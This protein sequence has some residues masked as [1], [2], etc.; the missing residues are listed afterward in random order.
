MY[1]DLCASEQKWQALGKLSIGIAKTCVRVGLFASACSDIRVRNEK[2]VCQV[3]IY[4]LI[5][6]EFPKRC[7]FCAYFNS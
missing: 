2:N 7:Y 1:K 4:Y 3:I 5:L 6:C